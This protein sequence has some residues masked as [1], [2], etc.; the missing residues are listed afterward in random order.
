MYCFDVGDFV[1]L[2]RAAPEPRPTTLRRSPEGCFHSR[3]IHVWQ[4]PIGLIIAERMSP[5]ENKCHYTKRCQFTCRL[6]SP[7]TFV[8]PCT[9][10]CK[11]IYPAH[12]S[13]AK[14]RWGKYVRLTP[15]FLHCRSC[16]HLYQSF[17]TSSHCQVNSLAPTQWSMA[18]MK[19]GDM[20][21]T[22][23]VRSTERLEASLLEVPH[24][25]C[26]CGLQP[27]LRCQPVSGYGDNY[28]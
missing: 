3:G 10:T 21:S 9:Y 17:S 13:V 6:R 8:N 18:T 12:V 24:R 25:R 19:A 5:I 1:V 28:P 14:Q 22:Y 2:V 4:N 27:S 11:R 16:H 15:D 26:P 20:S 23:T 7:A